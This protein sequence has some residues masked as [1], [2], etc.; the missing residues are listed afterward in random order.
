MQSQA[1]KL[2]DL[3][4]DG[5]AAFIASLSQDECNALAYDWRGF[6]ARPN[7]IAPDGDWDIWIALAGRGFGK[8]RMGAEWVKEKVEN[9]QAKRIAL[10]AETAADGRANGVR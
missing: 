2:A 3:S 4:V 1:E 9:G 6:H 10:I 7:Q 5:R 8:T